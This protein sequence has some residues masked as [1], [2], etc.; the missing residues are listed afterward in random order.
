MIKLHLLLVLHLLHPSSPSHPPLLDGACTE[1][2][3]PQCTK[4]LFIPGYKLVGGGID[5]VT[6]KSSNAFIFDMDVY[7]QNNTCMLCRDPHDNNKMWKLPRAITDWKIHTRCKREIKTKEYDNE[8]SVAEES[9]SG[10]EGNWRMD[11]NLKYKA[12]E[13]NVAMGGSYSEKTEFAKN[14]LQKDKYSF[15]S[16]KIECEYY[17]FRM[18]SDYS[19]TRHFVKALADLPPSY[20]TETKTDYLQF[21]ALYGTH[22]ITIAKVGARAQEVTAVKTCELALNGRTKEEVK[23]CLEAESMVTGENGQNKGSYQSKAKECSEKAKMSENK[24]RFHEAY[25]ERFWQVIGGKVTFDLLDGNAGE[26][27]EAFT[28]WLESSKKIPGL[29]TYSLSPIHNLVSS[30]SPKRQSLNKAVSEYINGKALEKKCKCPPNG[31]MVH[32]GKC[33]CVC[34]SNYYSN[35][36]CCP[37]R[38]G[39]A[40]LVVNIKEATGL[41]GDY[42]TE[43]DAYVV[44]KFNGLERKTRTIWDTDNPTW[45]ARFEFGTVELGYNSKYTIEVWDQDTFYDEILGKCE[46]EL[47]SGRKDETCSRLNRGVINYSLYVTCESHLTGEFCNQYLSV[48]P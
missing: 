39:M 25:S 17:S 2:T 26:N 22:Y 28:T 23:E 16:S 13:S 19:L 32:D 14:K 47:K 27:K 3:K 35:S 7:L 41:Y 20:N 38:R 11:L 31:N 44:F 9:T 43:A 18:T 48:P 15:F 33:S 40:T 45:N 37:T 5:I 4:T 30:Q 36:D 10:V 21:I 8:V 29:L 24:K 12:V 1:G 6:M 34:P 42:I 46:Y